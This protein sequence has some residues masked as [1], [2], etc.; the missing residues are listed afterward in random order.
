VDYLVRAGSL[1]GFETLVLSLG[2][3]PVDLFQQAGLS[4]SAIRDPD[5]LIS[6]PKMT[7]LL[8]IS[9]KACNSQTFGLQLSTNQGLFTVGAIGLYMAQQKSIF[10]SLGAAIR[11]VHM[12]AQGAILNLQPYKDGY[13]LSFQ[14]AFCSL[15]QSQQLIQLSIHLLY[16]MIKTMAG[17]KWEPEKISFSQTKPS[18]QTS[19]FSQTLH[20]PLEFG[21]QHNAIFIN[22][23]TLS[24]E[25]SCDQEQLRQ[26][27]NQHFQML[28]QNYPNHLEAQVSHSIRALLPTGDCTL[29][30]IAAMLDLHPRVMQKRLKANQQSF[31]GLL[32]ETRNDIACNLIAH[33]H[34]PLTELALQLGYSELAVFSRNFKKRHGISPNQ[35]RKN[36]QQQTTIN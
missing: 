19:T 15:E 28:T 9:A 2:S 31:S 34:I 6:Y 7:Q 24:L 22:E 8:E 33:S 5:T 3:N 27:I 11:Y 13:W 29:K 17:E 23:R 4:M 36:H 1:D 26:H 32:A 14:T 30:N 10:D 18:S 25:P 35:W 12:H 21:A 20:C 16:R